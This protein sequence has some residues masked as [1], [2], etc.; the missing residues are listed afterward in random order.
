V[1]W[2]PRDL[3]RSPASFATSETRVDGH[4]VRYQVTGTGEPAVLVHGLSG[5]TFWWARNV[6][7]LAERHRVYLVD[8]PGFGAM[9]GLR[10]QF[11]LARAAHWLHG[12]MEA[13]D[14]PRAAMVG[15]SMGGAICLRLAASY[16]DAVE[17]LVLAA[18]A[19]IPWVRSLLGEVVPLVTAVR[20]MTPSFLPI[21]TYD[22][23][24]AGPR[25]LLRAARDTVRED[26]REAAR[27]IHV[28]ALLIW[29]EHD[30]LV[31][32]GGGAI[33]RRE[34][35]D[36]RLLLIPEAG[37][38]VMFDRP[39]EFNAALLAFLAGNTVGE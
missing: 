35:H 9:R 12:W 27:A 10:S 25:T 13:V 19:G 22:V 5:S 21:L 11:A 14:L 39:D 18:P 30:T 7:P 33:L 17:R 36:A 31:P 2:A 23:L 34:M 37:H 8:L 4:V 24:R 32:S 26:V 6:W 16:P 29:G 20:F 3:W 38:V 15:H 1:I 28:P